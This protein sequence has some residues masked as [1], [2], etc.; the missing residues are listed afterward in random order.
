MTDIVK[1][2][3]S[4]LAADSRDLA[5][6]MEIEHKAVLQL[7]RQQIAAFEEFGILPFQMGEIKGR[8][9]PEKFAILNENQC[10]LLLT[11]VR[12]SKVTVPLKTKLIAA[13]SRARQELMR[14][15]MQDQNVGLFLLDVP[16]DWQRRFPESFF[17][18]L[19]EC[20]GLTYIKDRNTPSFV[21]HFINRYIYEPLMND[22]SEELKRKRKLH[23]RAEGKNESSYKLHQ[24]LKDHCSESLERH[25]ISIETLLRISAH[26]EEF[27]EHFRRRF[28][29]RHQFDLEFSA[30]AT[31]QRRKEA[32]V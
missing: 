15:Q 20:Y 8:G 14:V 13:F 9:Q 29:G 24:F 4:D 18:A 19:M 21:G 3:G 26:H 32:L 27:K 17:E 30:K 2:I 16:H 10:Y 7:I 11:F 12:N 1:Q 23:C 22:L 5:K 25:V 31:R 6:V 28:E